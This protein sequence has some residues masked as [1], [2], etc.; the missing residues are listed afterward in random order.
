MVSQEGKQAAI[1]TYLEAQRCLAQ[2][3]A[4]PEK[5]GLSHAKDLMTSAKKL[6]RDYKVT[7]DE[8]NRG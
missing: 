2:A 7:E 6:L 5:L 1:A 4:H 8:A 3:N